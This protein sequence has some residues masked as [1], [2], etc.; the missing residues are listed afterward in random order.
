MK[1]CNFVYKN[2]FTI[3]LV[4]SSDFDKS[5]LGTILDFLLTY[6]RFSIKTIDYT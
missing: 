4:I 5:K 3:Y 2:N 1:N 6:F